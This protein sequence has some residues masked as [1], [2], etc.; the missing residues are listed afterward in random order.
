MSRLDWERQVISIILTLSF[1]CA[2]LGGD[3]PTA[4]GAVLRASG[5]VQV[6]GVGSREI[7]TL[8]PGDSIQ[9][10]EDSAANIIAGGRGRENLWHPGRRDWNVSVLEKR[11]LLASVKGDVWHDNAPLAQSHGNYFSVDNTHLVMLD[12]RCEKSV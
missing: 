9:T 2:A 8:F 5:N 10:T 6:N 7:T 4:S 3:G 1:S 12:I 11:F